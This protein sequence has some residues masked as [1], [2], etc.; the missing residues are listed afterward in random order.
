MHNAPELRAISGN[1]MTS[2][3]I[4][5]NTIDDF[6]LQ[7]SLSTTPVPATEP[8]DAAVLAR[9]RSHFDARESTL[10]NDLIALFISELTRRLSAIR[11]AT[12]RADAK[13]MAAAAHV[14]RGSSML[15]G[16]LTMAELCLGIEL[17]ARSADAIAQVQA[18]LPLLDDEAARVRQAL[19]AVY[20]EGEE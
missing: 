13:G 10:F 17:A 15:V 8:I 3:D 11:T 2:N 12:A 14:L 20:A 5:N 7:H 16:A 6:S 19:I 18:V 9:L 1:L 4:T